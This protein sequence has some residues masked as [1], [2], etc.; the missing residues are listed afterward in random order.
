MV[1]TVKERWSFSGEGVIGTDICEEGIPHTKRSVVTHLNRYEKEIKELK[2]KNKQ[3]EH[4]NTI[5]IDFINKK[6]PIRNIDEL[7]E[8]ENIFKKIIW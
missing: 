4:N 6:F 5:L 7:N 2:K 8:L 3:L 1:I